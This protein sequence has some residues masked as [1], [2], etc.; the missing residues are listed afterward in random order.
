MTTSGS[1]RIEGRTPSTE[2]HETARAHVR[3]QLGY[4]PGLDGLRAVAIVALLLYHAEFPWARGSY[5][6]VSLFFTLSGF[7]VTWVLLEGVER[8]GAL[9]ARRFWVRRARRLWPASLAGLAMVAV[10]GATVADASQADPLPR[11]VAAAALNVANWLFIVEDTSYVDQFAAPSPVQHFWSLAI[12]EQFYL[13]LPVV[14]LAVLR[15][16]RWK[17][18]LGAVAGAGVLLATA[19]TVHLSMSDAGVDRVYYGTDTRMPEL[20]TGVVLAV[21]LSVAPA[22]APRVWRALAWV[23][24]AAFAAM[25]WAFGSIEITEPTLWR[26]GIVGFSLI[27][28]LVILGVLSDRGPLRVLALGPLVALGRISYGVYVYH[29][30]IYLWLTSERTGLSRWPLFGLRLT[31]T[32]AVA[33]ASYHLLEMPIRSGAVS[34]GRLRFVVA[35]AGVVAIVLVT[36][37]TAGGGPDDRFATLRGA[38]AVDAPAS[39]AEVDPVLDVVVITDQ[40]G[41]PIADRL[42]EIAAGDESLVVAAVGSFDCGPVVGDGGTSTCSRWSES[43][44][45]LV[46]AHDPDVV[47]LY[48]DTREAAGLEGIADASGTPLVD[49]IGTGVDLLTVNGATVVWGSEPEGL[50]AAE[51]GRAPFRAAME[52]LLHNRSDLRATDYLPEVPANP[53]DAYLARVSGTVVESL[54]TY[55][56]A[57]DRDVPR[58]M[59]VGDSQARS[60][61]YGL[62]L[63]ESDTGEAVVWNLAAAGCGLA[64]EGDVRD[65]VTGAVMQADEACIEAI[66]AWSSNVDEFDPDIVLVLSSLRDVQDRRLEGAGGFD[67]IGDGAIDDHLVATYTRAV[68]TLAANGATV[69]WMKPPCLRF[70]SPFGGDGRAPRAFDPDRIEHLNDNVLPALV[71]ARPDEVVLF[72]LDEILCPG[73][74]FLE[75]TEGLRDIRPDGVHLSADASLWLAEI[76]HRDVVERYG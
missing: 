34:L 36:A 37:V 3:W 16:G 4:R 55:R 20:L 21:V 43:W 75:D 53:D 32:L 19:W 54:N 8:H 66:D 58:V 71:E 48:T 61:G 27:A 74:E 46:D 39:P 57:P 11:Q 41:R 52:S 62:E 25:I 56:R 67:V 10:Y 7:L 51:G 15:V 60:V 42:E 49:L 14:L 23:G 47:F 9:D 72:G 2:A 68:D 5:L 45:S 64:V 29:L 40:V 12:E 63:L 22:R 26:G 44:P 33:I 69:V 17:R 28:C 50:L 30:P 65:A 76:L 38:A 6:S 13:G 35:P 1:R 18:L 59:I 73:G 70:V 24:A 31:A